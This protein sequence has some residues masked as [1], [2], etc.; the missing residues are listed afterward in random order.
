MRA[1]ASVALGSPNAASFMR[2]AVPYA[3][4][5]K[6]DLPSASSNKASFVQSADALRGRRQGRF[7]FRIFE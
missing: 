4:G 1:K 7:A 3:G 2:Q 5:G 6:G